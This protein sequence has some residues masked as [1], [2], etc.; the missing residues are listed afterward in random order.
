MAVSDECKLKFLELIAK[1]NCRFIIFKIENQ[2]VVVEK[3]GIPDE[4]YEDFTTS[5]PA[6]ERRYA[7]FNFDFITDQ[8]FQKSKLFFIACSPFFKVRSKAVY[9]SSKDRFKSQLDGIHVELQATDPS[10]MS[11]DIVKGRTP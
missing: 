5:Q 8:S 9:A 3:L 11:F 6:S 4:A 2:E 1:R 7:V 10:E